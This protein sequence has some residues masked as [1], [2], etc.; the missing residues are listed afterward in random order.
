[1]V[2]HPVFDQRKFAFA[3]AVEPHEFTREFTVRANLRC[4]GNKML[5]AKERCNRRRNETMCSGS[6]HHLV[7]CQSPLSNKLQRFRTHRGTNH[8]VNKGCPPGFQILA[9][10][11]GE[12]SKLKAN[13]AQRNKMTRSIRLRISLNLSTDLLFIQ[14][15]FPHQPMRPGIAGINRQ[16]RMVQI[17]NSK[18][19]Y[20]INDLYRRAQ[21]ALHPAAQCFHPQ[22]Y[23][24]HGQLP[25]SPAA[26]P[27]AVHAVQSD[28]QHPLPG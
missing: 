13:E 15:G 14:T 8:F 7:S 23:R 22:P 17:K 3:I 2:R 4:C 12:Q 6:E 16:K 20:V 11:C 10:L 24:P 26:S 21:S 27:C 28:W 5:N 1:M 19:H 18:L 9:L 25:G